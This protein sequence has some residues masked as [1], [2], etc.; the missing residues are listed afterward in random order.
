MT[1][2]DAH[3][4]R[5]TSLRISVT[6]RCNLRCAYCMPEEEYTWIPR[7]EILSF[8]EVSRLARIFAGLGAKRIRLTGGEPLLRHDLPLL[9]SML[10]GIPGI[11]DLALTT[12]G[13]RLADAVGELKAA[14]LQ[15]ITV[16]L[17]TL[18]RRRFETLTRRSG[19]DRVLQGLEAAAEA[20]LKALKI[21]TVVMRGFNDDELPQLLALG[22]RT[23][24][25][26]RFIE[27][28]DV[29]GATTWKAETV[30]SRGEILE[31]ITGA[32]GPVEA[33][34]AEATAPADRFRLPDGTVFG[35]ISS[36]TRPF[37]A[38]CD[39]SRLTADGHSFLC[40]YARTGMDLR[41][42]LRSGCSDEE[43]AHLIAGAWRS[44]TD[45]GAEE[46]LSLELRT[47]LADPAH[48][49]NHPH[50]EMHRRGG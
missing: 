24:A 21:N 26:V 8:E 3:G 30:V 29:G 41:S 48:L 23:G 49:R 27:Y 17:D 11:D 15:R 16:S 32:E 13:L 34:P 9:I 1:V 5:L 25:E 43:L 31:S 35:I 12:N 33:L 47:A 40:L 46:R 42:P 6:D 19:L 50:L 18:D 45:R 10:R 2:L 4:R 20:G 38:T 22:R 39:R 37:C 28:M 14:G 7:R 36:T 44:R